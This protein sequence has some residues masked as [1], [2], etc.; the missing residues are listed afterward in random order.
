MAT[1]RRFLPRLSEISPTHFAA[2]A[3]KLVGAHASAL[4]GALGLG[5]AETISARSPAPTWEGLAAWAIGGE[6]GVIG[7]PP[8][9]NAEALPL[10][11][12]LY[13]LLYSS[14]MIAEPAGE[15]QGFDT[16]VVIVMS[17]AFGRAHLVQGESIPIP[18]LAAL[19]S[20]APSRVRQLAQAGEVLHRDRKRGSSFRRMD[21]P[22]VRADAIRWLISRCVRGFAAT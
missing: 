7:T 3:D 1:P 11:P 22:I 12:K 8:I 6:E 15:E 18:Q 19:G 10:V 9:A 14:A 2:E 20:M 13:T 5:L 4:M 21:A 16:A 17:A